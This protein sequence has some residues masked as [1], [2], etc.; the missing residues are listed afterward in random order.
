[1]IRSDPGDARE[2]EEG[3]SDLLC[4][5]SLSQRWP[6]DNHRKHTGEGGRN[7]GAVTRGRQGNAREKQQAVPHDAGEGHPQE[8]PRVTPC[9]TEAA[10]SLKEKPGG[11]ERKCSHHETP[12]CYRRRRGLVGCG[13]SNDPGAAPTDGGDE[14][15]SIAAGRDRHALPNLPCKLAFFGVASSG[16]KR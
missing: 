1:V 11:E 16:P 9:R 15:E 6:R 3:A 7:D 8:Q 14:E 4:R 2:S 10:I 5:W 12:Y 13:P